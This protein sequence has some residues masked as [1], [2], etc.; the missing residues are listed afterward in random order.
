MVDKFAGFL[1]V[2]TAVGFKS[3]CL[4]DRAISFG[5]AV[6]Q[7]KILGSSS[8][9]TFGGNLAVHVEAFSIRRIVSFWGSWI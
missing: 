7:G 6:T 8:L 4:S 2:T 3:H 9:F 5:C 1:K